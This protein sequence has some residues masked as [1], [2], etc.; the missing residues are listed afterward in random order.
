MNPFLLLPLEILSSHILIGLEPWEVIKFFLSSKELLKIASL[1][2]YDLI[3]QLLKTRPMSIGNRPTYDRTTSLARLK[4]VPKRMGHS[5]ITVLDHLASSSPRMAAPLQNLRIQT[6]S[7]FINPYPHDHVYVTTIVREYTDPFFKHFHPDDAERFKPFTFELDWNE[8]WLCDAA[9]V[10]SIFFT[11]DAYA[12]YLWCC[13]VALRRATDITDDANE[14]RNEMSNEFVEYH[15][16]A[17]D[18]NYLHEIGPDLHMD[19]GLGWFLMRDAYRADDP[20]YAKFLHF[21]L[22]RT[23]Y[24]V[25]K[26]PEKL[27]IQAESASM[28]SEI[29]HIL[30]YDVNHLEVTVISN[31]TVIETGADLAIAMGCVRDI[32][33]CLQEYAGFIGMAKH[34]TEGLSIYDEAWELIRNQVNHSFSH[35][36]RVG[37]HA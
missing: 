31:P 16:S 27:P 9:Q 24:R 25:N 4:R 21:E 37:N 6:P 19:T 35:F 20:S 18:V 36:V 15:S 10:P 32:H 12:A 17:M 13:S 11:M 7:R 8:P 3:Q 30:G 1:I 2:G 5:H 33:Y 34:R 28:F 14:L 26:L 29:H 22:P 23:L